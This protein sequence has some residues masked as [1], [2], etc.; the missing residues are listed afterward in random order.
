MEQQAYPA[1]YHQHRRLGNRWTH[2]FWGCCT[3]VDTCLCGWCCPCCLFGK[4][5]AR[6]D[7]PSLQGFS[8]CN[9]NCCLFA[10]LSLCGIQWILQTIRHGDMRDRFGIDEGNC[11]TDCM[12]AFCCPCCGLVQQE[13]EATARLGDGRGQVVVPMQGYQP[14]VGMMYRTG[15]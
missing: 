5:Q 8:Y 12:G 6:L 15:S 13:K 4:T 7:D 3:P 9:G 1:A 14:P 11:C 10:T 2:S